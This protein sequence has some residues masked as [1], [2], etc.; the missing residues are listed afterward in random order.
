VNATAVRSCGRRIGLTS[1]PGPQAGGLEW[2]AEL[3]GRTGRA[4]GG[5]GPAGSFGVRSAGPGRFGSSS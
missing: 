3:S 2:L 4:T 5:R 1:R